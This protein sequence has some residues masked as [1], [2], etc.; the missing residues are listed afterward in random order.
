MLWHTHTN[1]GLA[2]ACLYIYIYT[3]FLGQAYLPTCLPPAEIHIQKQKE[4]GLKTWDGG[5]FPLQEE[6]SGDLEMQVVAVAAGPGHQA[7]GQF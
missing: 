4:K 7:Q 1:I 5:W 3:Y 6:A 2:Y